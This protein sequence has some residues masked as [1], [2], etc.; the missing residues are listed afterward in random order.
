M[1][2]GLVWIDSPLALLTKARALRANDS[3][4]DRPDVDA[5]ADLDR[6]PAFCAEVIEL[7]LQADRDRHEGSSRPSDDH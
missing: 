2:A 1:S 3:V 4:N 6:Q 5:D 7:R